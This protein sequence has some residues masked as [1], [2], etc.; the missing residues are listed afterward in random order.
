MRAEVPLRP[1][2]GAGLAVAAGI[3][4]ALAAV[5]GLLHRWQ[6]PPGGARGGAAPVAEAPMPRLQTAPQPEHHER[7][8]ADTDRLGA[9]GWVDRQNGI[10]HIP[11]DRA[12]ALMAASAASSPAAAE[13]GR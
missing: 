7:A 1:I 6:M 11:I 10:A 12:M 4:I 13:G 3:A 8:R 2:L 9:I 5:L